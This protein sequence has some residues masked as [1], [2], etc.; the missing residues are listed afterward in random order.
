MTDNAAIQTWMRR[1]RDATWTL[2]P[3]GEELA[4][5]LRQSVHTH[6]H[7]LAVMPAFGISPGDISV[8]DVGAGTGA[9]CLDI[10]W[11]CGPQANVTAVDNDPRSI[12]LLQDLASI[13]NCRVDSRLGEASRL[14]V[15]SNSQNLTLSRFL[16][17]HLPEPA[18]ALAEMVRVTTPGGTVAVM[19]VDDGAWLSHPVEA[20]SL[21]LLNE[22]IRQLQASR[23]AGRHIGRQ[24]YG[25]F[26]S[27]GLT[28]LQ[29]LAVPRVRLGSYYG[30]NE[31]LETHQREY[32]RAYRD[33]LIEDGF[34]TEAAFDGAMLALEDS[35]GSD[36]FGFG[37]EFLAIGRKPEQDTNPR[38]CTAPSV[39]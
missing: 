17:Q 18:L 38:S 33:A 9:M 23:G 37:C 1:F 28:A 22:A 26:R 30:R 11:M 12:V 25:M 6:M 32:Y 2:L 36:D 31:E 21:A 15:E 29:I 10:A 27:A 4:W 14:P 16:L 39:L 34:M 19:D 5:L 8:L 7:R 24:L 35:F 13:L 3:K 20:P